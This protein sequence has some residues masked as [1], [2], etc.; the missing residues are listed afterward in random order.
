MRAVHTKAEQRQIAPAEEQLAKLQVEVAKLE[1]KYEQ[2]LELMQVRRDVTRQRMLEPKGPNEE[3]RISRRIKELQGK[4]AALLDDQQ[5]KG[6]DANPAELKHHT[7]L[8]A[9]LDEIRNKL[10]QFPLR[11]VMKEGPVPGTRHTEPGDVPLFIRGD[12]LSLGDTVPRSIPRLFAVDGES[13]EISG[14]GR[15]QL[16][17]WLTR[18][19]H[20]LTARVMANRIW[21][22]L[23]GRGI[24]ATPSN[25]G[26]LGQRS[27][28]PKLLD[29]LAVRLIESGWSIKSLIHEIMTSRTYQQASSTSP[30]V[31]ARDPDNRWFGRMNR[32]RLDAESLMDTLAW[33]SEHVKRSA[34]DAPGW[35]LALSGRTLFGEFT[36]DKPQTTLDLFD[37]SSPDL[38]VPVRPDSTS[39]PQALFMLNNETVQSAAATLAMKTLS[40]FSDQ[41]Q[42]IAF[43]HQRLFAR[44][45]FTSHWRL[46]GDLLKLAKSTPNR[47]PAHGK[48]CASR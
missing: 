17:H 15:L 10:S 30:K 23:F 24:V 6:W 21:Q 34:Q 16:A 45:S 11:L 42:R 35:K 2:A 31:A 32:K 1:E 8:V 20:P 27:T 19:D 22:H 47:T 12:H 7:K 46:G 5:K 33:H 36:R 43:L 9:Q 28:H 18:A 40:E 26:R 14:S 37:G 41:K 13:L 38:V 44:K 48:I 29:Y 3:A 4:E 25:F 39:A